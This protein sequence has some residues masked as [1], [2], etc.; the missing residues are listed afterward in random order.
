MQGAHFGGALIGRGDRTHLPLLGGAARGFLLLFGQ[1]P[2]SQTKTGRQK[3]KQRH[4]S[5]LLAM[6]NNRFYVLM[7]N[8]MK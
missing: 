7:T 1:L 2:T 8:E 3:S 6:I 5:S 4:E